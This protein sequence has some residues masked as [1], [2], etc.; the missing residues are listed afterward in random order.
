PLAVGGAD[1][2]CRQLH[3]QAFGALS[4]DQ[5]YG[6]GDRAVCR[7]HYDLARRQSGHK[8]FQ[9]SFSKSAVASSLFL[10]RGNLSPPASPPSMARNSSPS[11][12]RPLDRAAAIKLSAL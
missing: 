9:L 12:A 6:P 1:G 11:T 7:R 5:L 10:K 4:L 2:H 3:R 8:R